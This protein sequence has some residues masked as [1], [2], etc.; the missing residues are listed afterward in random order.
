[1]RER[2]T[3]VNEID[4]KDLFLFIL[5]HLSSIIIVSILFTIVGFGYSFIAGNA[6]ATSILDTSAKLPDETQDAYN[7]RVANVDR[8]RDILN[9]ISALTSQVEIQN[10]YLSES[11]Y[12]QIDPLNAATTKIQVVITCDNSIAGGVEAL[13]NA[14]SSDITKGDYINDVANTL[15]YTPG[16]TQELISCFLVTTSLEYSE[17]TNQMG[18]MAFSVIGKT[19]DD[20]DLIMNAIEDELEKQSDA[21]SSSVTPHTISIVGRQSY[22]GYDSNVRKNQLDSVTTLNTLQSQINNLN[23]N[24]DSIAKS[25][26]LAD[27]TNLYEL[28]NDNSVES[29]ATTS[30][31]TLI[32]YGLLGFAVGLF[33][34]VCIYA[35]I[36]IFGRKIVSQQQFFSL[37]NV[38]R[39]GVC[40]PLG[41]R[42]K[43]RILFDKWSSDDEHLSEES[44]NSIIAANVK[45][46]TMGAGRVLIT[47]SINN[48][49]IV[50]AIKQIGLTD[51]I[52]LDMFS[53]PSVLANISEYDGVIL[54]EQRNYAQR[55]MINEELRLIANAKVKIIGAIVI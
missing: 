49:C 6:P 38:E 34:V 28:L 32:K 37:F 20:T 22:F 54:V 53:D 1:M 45:N 33:I 13:Y 41:K 12:M 23:N 11:V 15:G 19:T 50:D 36:Y 46:M 43:I 8:A 2:I 30:F 39:I 21:Y 48:E 10:E 29:E 27:R 47:G 55:K 25:L 24:L 16:A 18:V 42:S 5:K 7:S 35:A 17:S 9:N 40:K 44:N 14:Y 51:N 31:K 26:G 3:K 52:K 4:L